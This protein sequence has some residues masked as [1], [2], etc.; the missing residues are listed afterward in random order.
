MNKKVKQQLFLKYFTHTKKVKVGSFITA[1]I[2]IRTSGA[3]SGSATQVPMLSQVE[4]VRNLSML[5]H[6]YWCFSGNSRDGLF[7]LWNS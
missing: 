4:A 5:Y 6:I 3:G 2:R 7:H 1:R